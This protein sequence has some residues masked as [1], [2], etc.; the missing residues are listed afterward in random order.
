MRRRP[1]ALRERPQA[2]S[3]K[4]LYRTLVYTVVRK[5]ARYMFIV[6]GMSSGLGWTLNQRCSRRKLWHRHQTAELWTLDTLLP[7][8]LDIG[9]L[10]LT[11]TSTCHF[12]MPNM[13]TAFRRGF[14]KRQ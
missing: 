1:K 13:K 14:S 4:Y 2:R 8:C 6:S 9:R 7:R 3:A 10:T 11:R 12:Y 5:S